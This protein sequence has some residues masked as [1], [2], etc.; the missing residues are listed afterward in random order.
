[1]KLRI[2]FSYRDPIRDPPE[3]KSEVRRGAWKARVPPGV[4]EKPVS[5]DCFLPDM[6]QQIRMIAMRGATDDEIADQFGVSRVLFQKWRKAYPGFNAAIEQGRA[7]PDAEVLVALHKKA[8]G[9]YTLPDY[10]VVAYKGEYQIVDTERHFGP[11][12]EAAKTWMRMRQRE[13]WGESMSRPGSSGNAPGAASGAPRESKTELIAAIVGMLRPKPD[14]PGKKPE[15][16]KAEQR[17]R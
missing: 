5:K 8:T 1:M 6:E 4:R 15:R 17:D 9:N 2:D 16:K 11:D 7:A 12:T 14:E 13:H 3:E 10:E